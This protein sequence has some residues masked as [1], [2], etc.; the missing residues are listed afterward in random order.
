MRKK[1]QLKQFYAKLKTSD[2]TSLFLKHPV[3]N[4]IFIL[5]FA[6]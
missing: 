1:N 4:N 5:I 2:G 3:D 6:L